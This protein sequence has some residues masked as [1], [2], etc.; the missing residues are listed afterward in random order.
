MVEIGA[1]EGGL[2]LMLQHLNGLTVPFF[3]QYYIVDCCTEQID[4]RVLEIPYIQPILCNTGRA[5]DVAEALQ[6]IGK[7]IDV[8]FIDACHDYEFVKN[9]FYS[10]IGMVKIGGLVIMHDPGKPGVK[11]FIDE[12]KKIH[13]DR[14]KIE[15]GFCV[16]DCH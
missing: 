7:P 12:I 10:F 16:I 4:P 14:I 3:S 2:S 1:L 11:K 13:S 15:N 9:D 6:F 5:A 8:L